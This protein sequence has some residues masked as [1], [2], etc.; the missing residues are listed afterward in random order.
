[1]VNLI[2]GGK[3]K[4]SDANLKKLKSLFDVYIFDILG[5]QNEADENAGGGEIADGLMDLVI[6][7][8][9]SAKLN[10]DFTTADQIRNELS[11]IGIVLKDSP[12][13]TTYEIG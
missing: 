4:I 7:L 2:D 9:H 12:E 6:K 8:R 5:F 10:K 3:E 1:M 11:K 13:G